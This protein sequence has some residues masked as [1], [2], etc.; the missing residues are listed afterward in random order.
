MSFK[1]SSSSTVKRKSNDQPKISDC[2]SS[3]H[4][5]PRTESRQPESGAICPICNQSLWQDN[6]LNN[7]HIDSCLRKV[8]LANYSVKSLDYDPFVHGL[9]VNTVEELPG[10]YIIPNF[11]TVDEE[12]IIM[13]MLDDDHVSRM[14]WKISTFNGMCFSK[15]WGVK[16]QFGLPDELRLVRKNDEEKGEFDV[17]D[18]LLPFIN[19]LHHL[20]TLNAQNMAPELRDF[21][22]NECNANS[23]FA[24]EKHYLRPHFDDRTLSGPILMNLSLGGEAQMTYAKPVN[25]SLPTSAIAAG[26]FEH[27]VRVPLPRRTLQL[28]TGAARW[29]YTH[30]IRREDVL[31][32]RRMSLTFRQ[33][34][35]KK[36]ILL[37]EA[38]AGQDIGSQLMRQN[39]TATG[40]KCQ[41]LG[42]VP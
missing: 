23:Y 29:S 17:P 36:G 37:P 7:L 30:E 40:S 15:Y 25:A 31:S 4:K 24:A 41:E 32:P 12:N 35:G 8:E 6:A 10:L 28:V 3:Q 11:I 19:R 18:I 21:K 38:R 20:V 34:G 9:S 13:E 42:S 39:G 2:W 33:S 1:R 27:T 26:A 14:K 5:K 22:P 16:T